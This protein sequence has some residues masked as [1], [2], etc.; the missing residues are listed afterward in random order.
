MLHLVPIRILLSAYAVLVMA[1]YA[2]ALHCGWVS[3]D[4]VP[5]ALA[6]VL[7]IATPMAT[8]GP[9]MALA[10][11]RWIPP[12]QTII[13]PYLGGRWTGQ[14]EFIANGQTIKRDATLDVAHTLT[15][16]RFALS[17][18]ES[19]SE[20]LVVHARKPSA[21]NAFVKLVY[22]YEVERREGFPGAGDRYR[23]CAFID[24]RLDGP[25]TMIGSYMAGQDR[26]GSLRVALQKR[27]S[28]WKLWR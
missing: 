14:L 6:G 9:L 7:K 27:T 12:F 16:I 10:A 4:T 21:P 25:R 15:S 17:T 19:T 1:A 11:W 26:A 13:F 2:F 8:V 20:T 3:I 23:G 18:V 24:V 22:I 5:R 28:F